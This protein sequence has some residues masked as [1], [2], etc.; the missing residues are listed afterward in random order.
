MNSLNE[1]KVENLCIELLQE[2]GYSYL[3]QEKQEAEREQD[4]SQVV[5]QSRLKSAIK[6]L[7]PTI[8]PEIHQ[9]KIREALQQVLNLPH[10]K[11]IDNNEAFH[12]ILTEGIRVEYQKKGESRGY[13]IFLI[14]FENPKSNDFLVCNQFTVTQN[15]EV[16]RTRP[17]AFCEWFAFGGARVKKILQTNRLPCIRLL[18]S[19]KTTKNLFP[20]YFFQSHYLGNG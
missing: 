8:P 13:S 9:D 20:N 12:K 2:Q 11:L 14:D 17:C 19:C 1:S 6:R 10:Q 16:R 5:L 18:P 4:F 15:N 3:S 7:N